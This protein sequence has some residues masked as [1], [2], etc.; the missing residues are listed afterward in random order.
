MPAMR[1]SLVGLVVLLA[2]A[3]ALA[4]DSVLSPSPAVLCL[5]LAAGAAPLAYPPRL[6][7]RK[8]H[9]TVE[10]ELTF[11]GP[12]NMPDVEILNER[13]APEGL[14]YAVR[15]HVRHLRLPCMGADARPVV[16][17]QSFVFTPNDGRKVVSSTP[18][19][20]AD[21]ERGRQ[22]KCMKHVRGQDRPEYPRGAIRDEDQGSFYVK[23]R[24]MA[25]DL[26]PEVE[27]LA[28][29]P[30]P[31][32]ESAVRKHL[33]DLRL[34]CL[35]DG[36]ISV[37][38]LYSFVLDGGERTLLKD[39]TLK[40]LVSQAQTVQR[41]V[42]FDLS[43]MSC[44]FAVRLTY[45]QPHAKNRVDELEDPVPARLPFLDWLTG[46]ILKLPADM[47]THVLGQTITVQIPC[48]VVDL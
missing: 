46:L 30:Y 27:M 3:Q 9:G 7:E 26:P 43:T 11:H 20:Q 10:A 2:G 32:L 47:N 48:G 45:W 4:A 8:D 38:Q 17:R 21:E 31:R 36:P 16:I 37:T 12:E 19:D 14:V 13:L 40:Q 29:S 39:R 44:P 34:P 35:K 24:F 15:R 42:Y 1:V 33:A 22:L 28:A 23:L 6:L 18:R 41:G 25:P 5:T